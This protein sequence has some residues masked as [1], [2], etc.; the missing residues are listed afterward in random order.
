MSTK[1]VAAA[2]KAFATFSQTT[3]KQRIELLQSIIATYQK[4]LGEI[5]EAISTE[6]G[7]PLWLAKGGAGSA[8]DGPYRRHAPGAHRFRVRGAARQEPQSATSRSASSA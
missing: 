1:A 3:K 6:M 8:R 2:K 5:A 7:A 4:H